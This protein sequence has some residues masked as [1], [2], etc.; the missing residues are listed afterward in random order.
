[1]SCVRCVLFYPS[2]PF[3]PFPFLSVP[4]WPCNASFG[5]VD[6]RPT[7][8]AAIITASSRLTLVLVC[9][10]YMVV[11]EADAQTPSRSAVKNARQRLRNSYAKAES[12]S[13]AAREAVNVDESTLTTA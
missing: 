7:F 8:R 5:E 3:Y 11:A 12:K 9:L 6:M 1:M 2:S 13:G 4:F 10:A